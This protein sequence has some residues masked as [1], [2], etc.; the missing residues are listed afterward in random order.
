MN[1]ATLKALA[2]KSGK[3]TVTDGTHTDVLTIKGLTT[4]TLALTNFSVLGSDGHG[5]TMIG[6][7]T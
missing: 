1:S 5:G 6:F 7:H 4:V 2:F 3:L